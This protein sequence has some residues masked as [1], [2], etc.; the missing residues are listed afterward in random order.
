MAYRINHRSLNDTHGTA[1]IAQPIPPIT[2]INV[3]HHVV[4]PS[5]HICCSD[6]AKR[7]DWI[8]IPFTTA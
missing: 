5:I 1:P 2:F 6:G 4:P 8:A 3:V 7:G